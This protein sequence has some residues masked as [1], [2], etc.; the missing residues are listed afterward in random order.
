MSSFV[1]IAIDTPA[2]VA[3]AVGDGDGLYDYRC[4]AGAVA[5]G[6]LVIVPFGTRTVVGVVLALIDTTTVDDDRIKDV[7]SIV[8]GLSVLS[9]D[10]LALAR[11]AARYY[12]RPLGE[13]II[14]SLP[15][16]L[17]QPA[18]YLR[19]D[20]ASEQRPSV[21]TLPAIARAIK[22]AARLLPGPADP[23]QVVDIALNPMQAAALAAISS[24]QS[25]ATPKPIL[26]YG[27]TG[28]GKTEVYM[29]AIAEVIA[30][31]LQALVLVPEINLTPQLLETFRT[32]LPTARIASLHS[33]H[34]VGHRLHQWVLAHEGQ[35]DV[36]LGTRMAVLASLPRLGLIVVDEEHDTSYK[37]QEG[38]RYS[39]RDLA[40]V[41]AR[42][43]RNGVSFPVVLASATP[44]LE[45]W[46]RVESGRYRKVVLSA[47]AVAEASLPTIRLVP[48]LRVEAPHGLTAVV[49]DA[50]AD[51]IARREPVLIFHNRR[52]YAP[53]LACGACGWLSACPCCSVN[54][55]FHKADRHLHC[56]HC[57]WQH[58]VPRACPTCGNQDLSAVGRGTQ[59]V[60]ESLHACFPEARIA[61]IDRD[62]TRRKGSAAGLLDAVHLGELDILVGTQML[63]K[64][65]DF[66]NVT[67]VC[68]L[69]AD[70]A[71]YSHD[72]RASE[73]LF[74]NLMQVAGRAGRGGS[75]S[76]KAEVLIQTRAPDHPLFE[77]LIAHDF[78]RFAA[79]QLE[80][81]KA[82]GLPPYSY[83]AV[84]RA[85]ARVAEEALTF[86][87]EARRYGSS[88]LSD[89][90][91]D[92][93][94]VLYDAVPMAVARVA[95]VERAQLL[96]E[97]HDRRSLHLFLDAWLALLRSERSKPRW[98][99]EVD[100]VD[101]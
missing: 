28:S 88:L 19:S 25:E 76:E 92:Q 100:P 1:R 2:A 79:S 14:P 38:L 91:L 31:G 33:G 27:I 60:E 54:A 82:A 34:A 74:S 16:P 99:V 17:R 10:W 32:R 47:R 66:R 8:E 50:I 13:V 40:I 94:V 9:A 11:F 53:V 86:L 4:A 30:L 59:R 3:A 12:Y 39:A 22:R 23:G 35:V 6:Q 75:R 45:S 43:G 51:R 57:G 87:D 56:H 95:N 36:L 93:R 69:D 63:A 84:L 26:L 5:V 77:A 29:R 85:E 44:S 68:V 78:D 37:Q 46:S 15:P 101:I 62:S 72:F 21:V 73:R 20:S 7:L 70:N 83:Q 90:Q 97:A 48:T 18:G 81:R 96:I 24:A 89:M 49:R 64:G 42:Q 71:L 58:R 98:H 67:L 55:V 80:E 41:R 61:R 65:H 52:G